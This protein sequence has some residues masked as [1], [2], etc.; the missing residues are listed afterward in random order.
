[1]IYEA[2]D[3]LKTASFS[4]LEQELASKMLTISQ[5][6]E[7]LLLLLERLKKLNLIVSNGAAREDI[8]SITTLIRSQI[9]SKNWNEFEHFYASGNSGYI[10]RLLQ[11]H[12]DLTANERRLCLLL[13]MNL[14]TKEISDM[15][16]QSCRAIEMARHRI[17]CKFGLKRSDNLNRYLARFMH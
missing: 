8:R 12:P 16:M 11:A 3:T 6:N 5:T 10:K 13:Q 2:N 9:K 15:T 1:M 14:S 17:R 7:F 4:K